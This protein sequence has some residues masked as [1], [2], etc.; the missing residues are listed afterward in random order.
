MKTF[1]KDKVKLSKSNSLMST[2]IDFEKNYSILNPRQTSPA[3]FFNQSKIKTT[4]YLSKSE[5]CDF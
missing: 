5:L 2:A 3:G 1:I 4:R